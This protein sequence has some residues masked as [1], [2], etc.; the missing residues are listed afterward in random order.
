ML[1]NFEPVFI[2][3]TRDCACVCLNSC[4]V[5]RHVS[6]PAHFA[7]DHRGMVSNTVLE[8]I[9]EIGGR[10]CTS[11]AARRSSKKTCLRRIRC[12]KFELVA[13]RPHLAEH[14]RLNKVTCFF[15]IN[16]RRPLGAT[17]VHG[18]GPPHM[19]VPPGASCLPETVFRA[20]CAVGP[21]FNSDDAA[22]LTRLCRHQS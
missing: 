13:S 14:Y 5:T 12:T 16:S 10:Y 2:V 18:G 1:A 17:W 20:M 7:C 4:A 21:G 8:D 11:L 22:K 3:C 15:S 6:C 19:W 9:F